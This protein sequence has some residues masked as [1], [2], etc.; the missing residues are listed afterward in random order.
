MASLHSARKLHS[1]GAMFGR[2][3]A[4]VVVG[5]LAV[6]G[7]AAARAAVGPNPPCDQTEHDCGQ[8]ILES[9]CCNIGQSAPIAP[10][11]PPAGRFAPI[12]LDSTTSPLIV[13]CVPQAST[14]DLLLAGYRIETPPHG[15][16]P[17]DLSLLL[18]VFLI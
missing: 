5:V 14:D 7:T 17:A 6:P 1:I 10:G 3:A 16:R 2:L 8:A 13:F 11:V 18:S 15:Y 9:C 12:S 4:L